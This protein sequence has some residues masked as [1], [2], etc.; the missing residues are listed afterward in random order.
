MTGY[1]NLSWHSILGTVGL[2]RQHAGLVAGLTA[3]SLLLLAAHPDML[4]VALYLGPLA[5]LDLR[6]QRLPDPLTA[7]LTVLSM[8]YALFF[9]PD[10]GMRM[11]GSAYVLAA[12]LLT[13]WLG[14][15]STGR[16]VLGGG[17][18]KLALTFPLL[19]GFGPGCLALVMA[20][21]IQVGL[22]EITRR[23]DRPI[24]FGPSL[25]AGFLLITNL[26]L[27]SA[28]VT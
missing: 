20:T 12:L 2:I 21:A 18:I 10:P 11:A 26:D 28:I 3:L 22:A 27:F 15:R 4:W 6:T 25:I 14:Y 5:A 7:S 1:Y 24:P 23:M 8:G 16:M 13:A 9:T 17:D 19:I